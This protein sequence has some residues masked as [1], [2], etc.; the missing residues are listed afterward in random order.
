MTVAMRAAH[1]HARASLGHGTEVQT[2]I[3]A[4]AGIHAA[5]ELWTPAFAGVT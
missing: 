3:P 4:Q 2:V 5:G 1:Q